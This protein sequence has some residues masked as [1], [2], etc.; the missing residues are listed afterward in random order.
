M[1]CCYCGVRKNEDGTSLKSYVC[2][3]CHCEKARQK[4]CE[5]PAYRNRSKVAAKAWKGAN[6]VKQGEADKRARRKL[7]VDAL[8]AYS[9]GH[10]RCV[11]CGEV[12][13]EFLC[14][15]HINNDGNVHR[16]L[17]GSGNVFYFWLRKNK[18][19]NVGVQV[20]CMNCNASKRNGG[21]CVHQRGTV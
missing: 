19:P 12:E 18:Y 16:K 4:Y 7:R 21:S 14:L 20:L 17:Y 11:C 3:L 15:D 5:D 13:L 8:N 1:K 10:P 9:E 2:K 6:R